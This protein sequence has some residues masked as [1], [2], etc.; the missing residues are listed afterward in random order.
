MGNIAFYAIKLTAPQYLITDARGILDIFDNRQFF[1]GP[2]WFLLC[3]FW[4]NI[5]FCVIVRYIKKDIYRIAIICFLGFTGWFMGYR[6]VFMPMFLD[7]A[8]TA[9]PFFAL[10]YYLKNSGILYPNKW[11]RYNILFIIFLW[12][13]S[14]A[15]TRLTHYRLSLH[16]NGIN[17]WSTYVISIT[18]VLAV[19][20]LC[21]M[22]KK[23]PLFSYM[24]RYSIILLCVHHLIYR[25]LKVALQAIDIEQL[26]NV[27]VVAGITVLLSTL[28]IPLCVKYIPWFVAQ[29]DLIRYK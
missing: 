12:G 18:S 29:K 10:G 6:G 3:L 20:F 2:I 15:L 25:P 8:M 11:D 19:L 13:I 9:L 16:Y 1:N 24:G 14:F 27:Y 23:L 7:V 26:N 21:K 17:G 4:C 5:Y 22:I 28:C